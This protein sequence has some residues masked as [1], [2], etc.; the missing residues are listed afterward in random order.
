MTAAANNWLVVPIILP[1][2]TAVVMLLLP[3][4]PVLHR[5]LALLSALLLLGVAWLLFDQVTGQGVQVLYLGGWPAPYGITLVA[6]RLTVMMLLLTGLV[7]VATGLYSLADVDISG[8]GLG[9][10]P[11]FQFLLA[12]VGGAFVTGDLFNLYVWFEVML[13]ASF[14]LL[15][16]GGR[17]QQILAAVKYVTINL[18]S[19]VL[20]LSAVAVLYGEAGTL[21]MA[22]LARKLALG[23]DASASP[24]ITVVAL[25]FMLAFGIKAAV[26]PLFFWLPTSYHTPAYAVSALFA[27]L[28]TKVGIYALVR[29]FTLIFVQDPDVTHQLLLFGALLTMLS[30]VLGALAQGEIR[31]IL[32]FQLVAHGGVILLGLALYSAA[33]L[34]AAL[35]YLIHDILVKT[36]LFLLA[37]LVY[38]LRGT[39]GLEEL[40]G[41]ARERPWLAGLF[42]ICALSLGGLPPLSGFMAKLGVVSSALAEDHYWSAFGVL[43]VDLLTLLSM[44][45]IWIRAFWGQRPAA[46]PGPVT[47][48]YAL[49]LGAVGLLAGAVVV[50]GLAAQPVLEFTGAMARQLLD[51]N[52]YV[53]AVLGEVR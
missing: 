34:G 20:F 33:T 50:L 32:S 31:L 40:G 13:V 25:L 12:G 46:A 23:E 8:V 10:H 26:F 4:R 5:W 24:A 52:D 49:G 41:L 3:Y 37:G 48:H 21:N 2:V 35:F 30:G 7:A 18:F 9:Y 22:D 6:D 14:V 27:G 19:S 36:A 51:P 15:V 43:L 42:L 47:G 45:L 28:L 44:A 38:W 53:A 1:L 39:T 17:R 16:S 29:T 11:L